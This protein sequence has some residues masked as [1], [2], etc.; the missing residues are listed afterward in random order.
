MTVRDFTFVKQHE[1]NLLYEYMVPD[2]EEWNKSWFN[3]GASL[4]VS[5]ELLRADNLSKGD[6]IGK[7]LSSHPYDD[8]L[9]C[10][11]FIEDEAN[12]FIRSVIGVNSESDHDGCE[13]IVT[14][15]LLYKIIT[16][17]L[18]T[19]T[20]KIPY[21]IKIYK[22]DPVDGNAV[23]SLFDKGSGAVLAKVEINGIGID[24][25]LDFNVVSK[26]INRSQSSYP[27][28]KLAPA[29]QC[30]GKE[31]MSV[32]II[33]GEATIEVGKLSRL[34]VNDVLVLDTPVSAKVNVVCEGEIICHG[35]LGRKMN[36]KAIMVEM[37]K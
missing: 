34:S 27:K 11:H 1:L 24:V 29:I 16:S 6:F 4:Q 31:K 15:L 7:W 3:N 30:L 13:G 26:I 21:P 28:P 19:L 20:K 33:A 9:M 2:L 8:G 37:L 14:K 22:I 23:D 35:S 25:L 36:K 10:V 12:N 18:Q 32:S 17:L 5:L